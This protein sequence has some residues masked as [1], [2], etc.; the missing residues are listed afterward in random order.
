M[1]ISIDPPQSIG[2]CYTRESKV[3]YLSGAFMGLYAMHCQRE[4][5]VEGLPNSYA[6]SF[7]QH[8]TIYAHQLTIAD[9]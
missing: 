6:P 2:K 9:L 3:I 8:L 7:Q 4:A 1:W 5:F